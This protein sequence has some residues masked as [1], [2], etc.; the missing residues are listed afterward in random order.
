MKSL[1]EQLYPVKRKM[2]QDKKVYLLVPTE[3]N[4][5]SGGVKT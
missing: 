2:R 4:F 5:N 3:F 1:Q